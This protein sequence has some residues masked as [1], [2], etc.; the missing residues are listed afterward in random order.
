VHAWL[1]RLSHRVV[2]LLPGAAGVMSTVRVVRPSSAWASMTYVSRCSGLAQDPPQELEEHR[3]G[4]HC[5]G[6]S[7]LQTPPASNRKRKAWRALPRS[8]GG[9]RQLAV[10]HYCQLP[11]PQ[12][13][14]CTQQQ[15]TWQPT[16]VLQPVPVC[17]GSS[18]LSASCLGAQQSVLPYALSSM[19]AVPCRVRPLTTSHL[20]RRAHERQQQANSTGRMQCREPAAA[21][22]SG[23]AVS[24][25]EHQRATHAL[26]ACSVPARGLYDIPDAVAVLASG[27]IS[28]YRAAG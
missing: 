28:S 3:W 24:P 15:Q 16:P 5:T 1:R 4:R 2:L 11:Q 14:L 19:L 7:L 25:W 20:H 17:D 13:L 27:H 6:T 8:E 10:L 23:N 26:P 22:I 18:W 9:E 12:S 21:A